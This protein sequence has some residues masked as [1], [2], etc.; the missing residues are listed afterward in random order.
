MAEEIDLEIELLKKQIEALRKKK[1]QKE[2][3]KQD[4]E[5]K[6]IAETIESFALQ[7]KTTPLKAIAVIKG[8]IEGIQPRQRVVRVRDPNK[9]YI[10]DVRA[11]AKSLGI[12]TNPK[13]KMIEIQE[14]IEKKKK[15]QENPEPVKKNK[16]SKSSVSPSSS[17]EEQPWPIPE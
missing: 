13:M 1:K 12:K 8:F 14:L 10:F 17:A 9:V 11:E 3:W 16:S 5:L 15:A 4:P 2:D 7:W 6:T